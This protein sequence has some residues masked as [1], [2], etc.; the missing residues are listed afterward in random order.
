MVVLASEGETT[1]DQGVALLVCAGARV[2]VPDGTDEGASDFHLVPTVTK[3]ESLLGVLIK[4]G[5]KVVFI[6]RRGFGDTGN[7]RTSTLW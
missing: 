4:F 2:F 3:P 5:F 7:K 6:G 1:V